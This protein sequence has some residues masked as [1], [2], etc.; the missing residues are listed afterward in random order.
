V[1][2]A[3]RL[4]LLVELQDRGS[5]TA[6]ADAFGYT[7]SAISQQLA[8]LEAETGRPL[9]EPVGRG[10]VLTDAGRT[11]A[12]HAREVLDRIEAAEASLEAG[13]RLRGTVRVAAFQTAARGMLVP[14]LEQL[15]RDEPLLVCELVDQEAET[16]LP[17]LR[18]GELDLVVADE[19]EHALRPRDPRLV[20]HELGTDELLVALPASHPA[21]RA[22]G[23]V[24]LADL[25]NEP[26]ATPWAGTYYASMVENACW[27]AGFEPLIRHRVTD[28][29]TLLDLAR[30]GLAVAIVP[31]LGGPAE[32]RAV[33]LRPVAGGGLSR[34]L[35][36][37]TRRGAAERRALAVLLDALRARLSAT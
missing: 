8:K 35:F 15:A 22:G 25:A 37:A 34:T 16:A 27:A 26:W 18:A 5:L 17:G 12:L 32:D 14:V 13:E 36:A 23:A 30:S 29:G 2:N 11:L 9:L 6:V 31:A 7:P 28:L 3:A 19:Y 24:A 1:L 21:A 10:V 33:A 20:R 4:S